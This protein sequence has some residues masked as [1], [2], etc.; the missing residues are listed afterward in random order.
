M[1]VAGFAGAVVA[2][3]GAG[4][5]E[6]YRIIINRGDVEGVADPF[7]R[8]GHGVIITSGVEVGVWNAVGVE[9]G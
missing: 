2:F 8:S 6:G 1:A 7:I 3:T 9:D 5:T 4:D